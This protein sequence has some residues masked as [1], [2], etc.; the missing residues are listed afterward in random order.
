MDQQHWVRLLV[1]S[2]SFVYIYILI[3]YWY[4]FDTIFF[5]SGHKNVQVGFG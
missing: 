4:I 1:D 3:Y 5:L 2:P